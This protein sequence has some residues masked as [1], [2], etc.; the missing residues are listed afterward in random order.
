MDQKIY[1]FHNVIA[2]IRLNS[3]L[4]G[5]LSHMT[6]FSRKQTMMKGSMCNLVSYFGTH[7]I[8]FYLANAIESIHK[9]IPL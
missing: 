5:R 8:Y 7:G 1:R 2:R 6:D 4:T 3:R 9:Y